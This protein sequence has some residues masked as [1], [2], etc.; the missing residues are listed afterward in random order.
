MIIE[1][2]ILSE[3]S[4]KAS[5]LSERLSQL[6]SCLISSS[7]ETEI[8]NQRL[9]NWCQRIGDGDWGKLKKRLE[10][11]NLTLETIRPFLANGKIGTEFYLPPWTEILTLW[12]ETTAKFNLNQ[13]TEEFPS[14]PIELNN[15]LPFEEIWLSAIIVARKKLCERLAITTISFEQVPFTLLSSR[16]YQSLERMLLQRLVDMGGKTL[17]HEFCQFRPPIYNGLNL[18]LGQL[19]LSKQL[20]LTPPE[21]TYYQAFVKNFLQDGLLT[22][23]KNYPVLARLMVTTLNFWVEATAEFILRLKDDRITVPQLQGKIREI[24]GSLSDFHNRGRS[25]LILTLESGQKIIYK[26]KNIGLEVAYNQLLTWCNQ[27][28]F[29]LPFKTIGHCDRDTYGWVLDYIE[30]E[31]CADTVAAQRF[32]QRGGMLLCLLYVLG[33]NDCH[34]ENLIAHGEH[35]VLIDLETL[36]HPQ[37]KALSG[38]L[39]ESMT[40]DRQLWDSVLRTGLLPRWD[41]SPDNAIAYDISGLGSVTPQ[42]APYRLPRWK[43]INTDEVY[44]LEE[45]GTLAEQANIPKLNGVALAP[46]DYKEDL[47]KGFTQMYHFLE[48]NQQALLDEKELQTTLQFQKVRFI[49]RATYVYE[50]LLQKTLAPEFLKNGVDR[51]I[52]IDILSRTFLNGEEKPT[53]WPILSAELAAME[54]LDI[55]YFGSMASSNAL[56]VGVSK[57]ITDY[58]S[59]SYERF[60]KRLQG[61]SSKDLKQQVAIVRGSFAARFDKNQS[62]SSIPSLPSP[63]IPCLT[64]DQFL[65]AARQ[66]ASDICNRSIVDQFENARWFGFSYVDYSNRFQFQPLGYSLYD[67]NC[68]IALFLSALFPITREDSF[69]VLAL[70]ALAPLKKLLNQSNFTL[71]SKFAQQIGIGAGTGIGSIIYALVKISKFLGDETVLEDGVKMANFI[72]SERIECDRQLDTIGGAAGAML[73]LLTLYRETGAAKVL[74]QAIKCGQILIKKR[75]SFEG[76]P[77]AWKTITEQPLTGFSHGAAGIAYALVRLYEVTEEQEYL[78]VAREGIAYE[79]AV[80]SSK[81]RNWPDFLTM[82]PTFKVM[83]CH[84]AAGI[85][86][87]R[88][89]GLRIESS[90]AIRQELE[91]ALENTQKYMGQ[92]VDHLCCGHFGRI[93]LL[94]TAGIVLKRPQLIDIARQ[95][96]THFVQQAQQRGGYQLLGDLSTVAFNPGFF[97]GMAGIGYQLL[98]LAYPARFPVILLWD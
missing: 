7:N 75:I 11:D 34:Y 30:Q 87:G 33:A 9:E 5:S 17:Y 74:Q 70:R 41:F 38:S 32:Y 59:S 54:Q 90:A 22:L 55:P 47:I 26:P 81:A 12:I 98:R 50:A 20:D 10:W 77:R 24:Q 68:G 43:F 40:G 23:W 1:T 2:N 93:E 79:R 92:S 64:S 95:K 73:G 56:T 21:T 46:Q 39:E 76:N 25:V 15:P 57:P 65:D 72:T 42:K 69:R 35:L 67:G 31:P 88:L 44:L 28:Q 85:G 58:L 36:M 61:M 94:L 51:S 89:G 80:F 91:I 19:N 14:F 3:I 83:W 37:A 18:L 48:E 97:Q 86:L 62:L 8:I 96:A 49:F 52:E 29:P 27:Q 84:G 60:I 45:R 53:A 63:S 71:S 16:A 13:V 66:I 6:I 82:P 78:D 4:L